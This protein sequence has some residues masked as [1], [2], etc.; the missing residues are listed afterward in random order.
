M[1]NNLVI[2]SWN[3]VK[4]A[5]VMKTNFFFLSFHHQNDALLI[6]TRQTINS[7]SYFVYITITLTLTVPNTLPFPYCCALA[8]CYSDTSFRI[9]IYIGGIYLTLLALILPYRLA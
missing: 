2:E 6:L 9:Y 1:I 7:L 8:V 4:A 5:I 3:L